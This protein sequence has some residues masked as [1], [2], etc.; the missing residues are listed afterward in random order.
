MM[1]KEPPGERTTLYCSNYL[2]RIRRLGAGN[3]GIAHFLSQM[4]RYAS[5]VIVPQ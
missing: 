4:T 2:N 1:E 5:F 3:L